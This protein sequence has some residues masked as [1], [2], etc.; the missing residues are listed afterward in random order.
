MY[1][2]A[3]LIQP[4]IGCHNPINYHYHYYSCFTKFTTM[5]VT[6]VQ[7]GVQQERV[8]VQKARAEH[9]TQVQKHREQVADMN[10]QMDKWKVV[11]VTVLSCSSVTVRSVSSPLGHCVDVLLTWC[12]VVAVE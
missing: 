7:A 4:V 5:V 11:V 3:V 10:A 1:V 9:E 6:G 12:V 8:D 2:C